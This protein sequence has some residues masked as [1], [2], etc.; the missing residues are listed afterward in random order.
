M[1]SRSILMRLA[2][3][4]TLAFALVACGG[5]GTVPSG[6]VSLRALPADYAT[7]HAAAYSPFRSNN[8]DT[9]TVT[10]AE[11]LQD[12]QLLL[13]ADIKLIRLFDSSD[14]VSRL[15]LQVIRANQ[16][17]IKVHLGAYV[18]SGNDAFNQ[19]EIARA[20][21]LANTYDDIVEAVSVGNETMVS[22]SFNKFTPTQIAAFLTSVRAG[23]K[24]PVTTDD[25]WAFWASAPAELLKTVD[26]VSLHTYSLLDTVSDPTSWDWQQTGVAANLRAAAMMDASIAKAKQDVAAAQTYLH[27]IGYTALPMVIGET[28]WKAVA[29]GGETLRAHTVNQK[30]YCDRL[31][32]WHASAGGPVNIVW[33]EAFDEPWKGGDDGWGLFDVARKARYVVQS[34]IPQ[35]DWEAGTTTDADAV[36]FIP[37]MAAGPV[38]A[39]R[40]T[41]YAETVTPG[42][43]LPS[44]A[45]AWGAWQDGTTAVATEISTTAAEGTKSM[46]I[47]PTPLSW[48]WGMTVNF[49]TGA[50]NLSNFQATGTLNFS[51]KTT[52]P[53]KVS[54]GFLTGTAT[55]ASLYDVYIPIA[56]G[57]YGYVNDG[58][59]HDVH[60][61]IS[62]ITPY[63]AM[64]FGMTDSTKAKLDLATVTNPFVINDTYAIT[65][66]AD[67]GNITT[68]I[69]VD[70]IYWAK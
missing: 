5:G 61:P 53:G 69:L 17:D 33:F 25:N 8:R 9:E 63:G 23:I 51:I 60:I 55:G 45:W 29:T 44:S 21:A 31:A 38:T 22:W 11:V 47:T 54:V 35:A 20:M 65:G 59:W 13:Q 12:L 15:T 7:R 42:E 67:G 2:L 16:L 36:Y 39:D 3:A 28:G 64:A 19:A 50:E 49:T 62:A 48:G 26:F 68:P 34:L 56:S 41:V 43:A 4:V 18:I 57:D 66:K 24:Q 10:S 30:M 40:Y 1:T 32:A 52:Y 6:G 58:A 70:G 27:G 37:T 14:N 46:Q